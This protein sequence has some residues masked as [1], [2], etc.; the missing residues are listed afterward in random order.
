M[1]PTITTRTKT[2]ATSNGD[3]TYTIT[4]TA[5]GARGFRDTTITITLA[6]GTVIDELRRVY[7]RSEGQAPGWYSLDEYH[8]CA[9][10]GTRRNEAHAAWLG[11]THARITRHGFIRDSEFGVTR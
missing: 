9:F 2:A 11:A 4:T 3:I 5:V 1:T 8:G 6:D 7:R 10:W